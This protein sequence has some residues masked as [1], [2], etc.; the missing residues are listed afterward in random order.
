MSAKIPT[1]D[2]QGL[3]N[4]WLLPIWS[5]NDQPRVRPDQVYLTSVAA[6]SR[7][8]PHLHMRRRGMF[9]VVHGTITLRV[10]SQGRYV[11]QPLIPESGWMLVY[12]SL[13]CALYN[14]GDTE[15]LVLNMPSPAWSAEDPDEHPV[16]NWEDPKDWPVLHP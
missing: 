10:R 12:P 6:H 11:D 13:A 5:A 4:G 8:G 9:Q 14:Y 1:F 3:P 15:A 16:E 7:K 2:S